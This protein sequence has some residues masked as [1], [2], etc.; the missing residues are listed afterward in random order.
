MLMIREKLMYLMYLN[1][2]SSRQDEPFQQN[3][4]GTLHINVMYK[5]GM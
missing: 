1:I 2:H 3:I 4:Y 5:E